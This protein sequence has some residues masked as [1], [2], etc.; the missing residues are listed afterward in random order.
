MTKTG[1]IIFV[2]VCVLLLGGLV[3]NSSNDRVD[4]TDVNADS[5]IAASD[6]N[7]QIADRVYG[8]RDAKVTLVEYGDYQCPG[9][10]SIYPAIK[11][12]KTTHKD[13]LAFVFRNFPLSQAHPNARAAAAAAEAAGKQN[14]FWEMHDLIYTNQN[15]WSRAS[16]EERGNYF[17]GWARDLGL[18]IDQFNEDIASSSVSRK[19]RFDTALAGKQN[20]TQTPTFFLN[21]RKLSD[22]EWKNKE[23]LSGAIETAIKESKK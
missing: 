12:L 13:D 14:K 11:E 9:C 19:I 1:W 7:G 23:A 8:N 4:V 5:L 16:A 17:E 21:G 3:W 22:D 2:A 15:E 6:N 18:N 10:G 20:V